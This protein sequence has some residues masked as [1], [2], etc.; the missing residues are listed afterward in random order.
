M[1]VPTSHGAPSDAARTSIARTD[2]LVAALVLLGWWTV[3]RVAEAF[4]DWNPRWPESHTWAGLWLAGVVAAHRLAPR[5]VFLA[6]CTVYPIGYTLVIRHAGLQSVFH[7][8]PILVASFAVA[9]SGRLGP[10]TTVVGSVVAALLLGQGIAGIQLML[11]P[12]GHPLDLSSVALVVA[13]SAGSSVLGAVFH[14]LDTTA[15]SLESSNA[16]LRAL[17]EV[18]AQQAVR[19]ERTRIARELHDVLAHHVSAIVVRAQAADHVGARDPAA[20]REAVRWIVPEGKEALQSMRAVVRVLRD[21][22][23]APLAPLPD[24]EDLGLVVDR[25]RGA[26]LAVTTTLPTALPSRSPAVGLAVVR[27]TQEALTNVLTHSLATRADVRLGMVG[28]AA[29]RLVLEIDDPG[30]PRLAPDPHQPSTSG[31][32]GLL[33][34]HERAVSCGGTLAAGPTPEGHWLVRMEVPVP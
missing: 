1:P 30:P 22:S 19:A 16:A 7:L 4:A 5:A 18:R 34:M 21:T 9:R 32:N 29:D 6:T 23:A 31:G 14:R 12:D 26:G 3:V 28:P 27:V 25:V 11:S 24:L 15:R 10:L 20:Y 8:L 2:G 13:L 17:Q 33:H